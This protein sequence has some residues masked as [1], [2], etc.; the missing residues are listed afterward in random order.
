ML[1]SQVEDSNILARHNPK[2]LSEV[3]SLAKDFLRVGD[4][5][6]QQH[7]I[8][9]YGQGVYPNGISAPGD[10]RIFWPV[11]IFWRSSWGLPV[12]RSVLWNV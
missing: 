8:L 6:R 2:V 4:L 1:M 10:A 9:G 5:Q 7:L 12:K 3:Q 11:T